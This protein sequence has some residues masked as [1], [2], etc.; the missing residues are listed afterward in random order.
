MIAHAAVDDGWYTATTHFAQDTAWLR[1]PMLLFSDYG[2]VVFGVLMVIAWR[3]A[4]RGSRITVMSVLWAPGAVVL[5]YAISNLLKLI[6]REP[7][8]CQALHG[9]VTVAPCDPVTD[10]SFPSNHAVIVAAAA[11]V[12]LVMHR[13]LGVLAVVLA[14]VMGISRVYV[15]AHYPHDV[16]AGYL[17]GGVVAALVVVVV[18]KWTHGEL[19]R[20]RAVHEGSEG[21]ERGV[22]RVRG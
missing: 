19:P 2:V 9:V 5:A 11:V 8:P 12:I 17:L 22:P 20:P 15:G 6:I 3:S 7:R 10:Y 4:Y 21:A 16:L 13:G 1:E 14:V 18:A